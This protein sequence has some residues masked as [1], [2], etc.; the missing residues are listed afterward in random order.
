MPSSG[1]D[2]VHDALILAVHVEQAHAGF[3]AIFFE[4]VKLQLR[5]LIE[6]RQSAVG[7]GNGMVHHRESQI[8]AADFAAFGT[9]A[10][11]SLRRSPLVNQVAININDGGLAG[12]FAN[13][14][15]IP[16]FW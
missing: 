4:R 2:D 10:R 9:Q 16:D 3:A 8:G 11:K 5:I 7:G 1:A 15:R 14:M 6:D 13:Q 12:F